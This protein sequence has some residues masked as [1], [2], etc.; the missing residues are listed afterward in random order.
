MAS[1]ETMDPQYKF[2]EEQAIQRYK[3]RMDKILKSQ[4]KRMIS[5]SYAD[6]ARTLMTSLTVNPRKR[7][8]SDAES[9]IMLGMSN[10]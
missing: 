5:L 8:A 2:N 1:K 6:V 9:P 10:E 4:K 7:K 3:D